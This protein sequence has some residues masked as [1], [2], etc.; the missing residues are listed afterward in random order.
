MSL[1]THAEVPREFG[2]NLCACIS[3]HLVKT[4]DQVE[5]FCTQC[6]SHSGICML[7]QLESAKWAYIDLS[8]AALKC[9]YAVHDCSF[10]RGAAKTAT[11]WVWTVTR[12]AAWSAQ[13]CHSRE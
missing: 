9:N 4:L 12:T 2:K 7:V 10:W 13:Q 11:S 5:C 3:C 8:L 6:R 1:E